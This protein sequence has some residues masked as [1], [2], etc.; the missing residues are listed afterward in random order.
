M[1]KTTPKLSLLFVH[2]LFF[3]IF[4]N[5]SQSAKACNPNDK[6]VLLQIKKHFNNASPFAK[7]NP[8]SDCCKWDDIG[9]DDEANP[10]RVMSLT[11]AYG[12][13]VVGQIPPIIGDLP[14]LKQLRM[15]SLPN[16]TGSIPSTFTKL[17]KL[18]NLIL[19]S[20]KLTGPIPDFL[21]KMK[22]LEMVDLSD[23]GFTGTI[24]SSLSLLPN[25]FELDLFRF[26]CNLFITSFVSK[27]LRYI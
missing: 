23:N 3:C 26:V 19:D 16:L 27:Y 11:I 2:L 9:C 13:D 18:Q 15:Y 25:L 12:E 1:E 22:S 8:K 10:G 14:Y 6:K 17:T 24:P 21:S 20:N 5:P 4:F 7:W